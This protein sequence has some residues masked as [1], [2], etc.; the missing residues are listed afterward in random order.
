ML[1]YAKLLLLLH[2]YKHRHKRGI[3]LLISN[4]RQESKEAVSPVEIS[5]NVRLFL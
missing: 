4:S 3:N 5:Q 1:G 2:I